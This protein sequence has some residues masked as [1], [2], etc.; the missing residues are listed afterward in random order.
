M[1]KFINY[2][3]KFQKGI[4]RL[5]GLLNISPI[6]LLLTL[7]ITHSV[8]A[9][10][11]G[12]ISGT[13]V[14]KQNGEPLIGANILLEG[15]SIGAATDINGIYRITN[16][17]VG[18]YNLIAS[19]IGY[20]KMTVTNVDVT[21]KEN[22][23]LDLILVSEA[24]E[25]EAVIVTAKMILNNEASLLKDRQKSTSISDAISSEQLSMT[26]A[27]DA[28]DAMK[29][30]VGSTV[31]DGK[32]V[33]VRGLGDRYSNTQLNGT[34]L[35]STDP[36]KK[37]FQLDLIPT[38][39]LENIITIKTFT[40]DK[41]GNF[42]GGIVDIGTKS[43]PENFTLKVSASSSYNNQTSLSS[44]FLTYETGGSDWL[45]YDDGT[46]SI[47]SLL[48]N[49][50]VVIPVRQ[51][52]RFNTDQAILLDSYSKSFNS[53][54][55]VKSSTAP[56]NQSY[57]FSMGDQIKINEESSFG[58]LGSLT[59]GRSYSFY[60][61]GVVGRYSVSSLDADILNPQLLVNDTKGTSEAN[62]GGLASFSYNFNPTQQIGGNVFYSRSGISVARSQAGEWPQEFGTGPNSP[63]FNNKVLN[64][65]E[66]DIISYQVRGQHFLS[67]LLGSTVDWSLS[68]SETNQDEPDFRLLS[69]SV[70]Q[71]ANGPN[72][73]ISG[74]GFDNPSRYFRALE[75][76]TQNYV[77]NISIP[78]S[79]WDGL[80]GKFKVGGFYQNSERTFTERIFSYSV[81]NQIFNQVGGNL[82]IFFSDQYTGITSVDTI[83]T[84]LRYNFGNVITDNSKTKNNYNGTLEVNAF[85][86][87]VELPLSQSLRFVGGIRY[88]STDLSLISKDTTQ[89]KGEVVE[90]DLLPSIN[91]IY[92]LTDNMNV[93]ASATQTLAR[94]NFREIAP[95][96]SKEFIN[97]VELAGNPTLKRTLI[98]N[99]D[100]RWEWFT[101]PGE[102]V[103]VSGFYKHLENPIE[104]SYQQYSAVS[105]PVVQYQN[106]E[107][108]TV[109]G[110]EL[111]FRLGLG[112]LSDFLSNFYIGT[113]LSLIY[114]NIDIA[115]SEMDQRLAIDSSSS[116]TRELQ[117]QSPYVFNVDLSY[118]NN[119]TG[120]NAGLYLNTFGE[121]LAK[122]SANVNPD[123]YEQPAPQ[124]NFTLS[125]IVY[126]NLT[127]KFGVMNLLNASYKEVARFK[128]Q[129]YTFQEYKRGI[130]YSLGVSYSL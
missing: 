16:V 110:V 40:P 128:D 73:I 103:A 56:V 20:T 111:E 85:Y 69:Y 50:N 62:L 78:F 124:L 52:A 87:M 127:L 33:Y 23:K 79:Q 115:Q 27:S 122:V 66:R 123:V 48:T 42:S 26:G 98:T 81:D 113:N 1:N 8:Y 24:I 12:T 109:A 46:R 70:G 53:N 100:L 97:D 13:I 86:G 34:E 19:M 121:R 57:S 22:L 4:T 80:N 106:V 28:G 6:L 15:T 21:G 75:D 84:T 9:Q 92:S 125:Q 44:N 101:N 102:V 2:L 107:K 90:D 14:D 60:E 63:V 38:N 10:E 95:Y 91:F 68:F 5:N 32:Y 65:T 67:P 74:S 29:K 129:D 120:T 99:Y 41:P 77:V 130:T 119:T 112:Q 51:Q 105:N 88:E 47:P 104:L 7:L 30:V 89:T 82:D 3:M 116:S 71:T 83:G 11:T 72:Y 61:N 96:S 18:S 59:Y 58:Y 54:M 43:F 76:N 45:G 64:W 108:A 94:P 17:P 55:N 118:S 25:T 117:G 93:R 31:V 114:S 39:L 35:P 37:A 49:E 126:Q 36:N